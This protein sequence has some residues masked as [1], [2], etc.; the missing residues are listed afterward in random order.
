MFNAIPCF[1]FIQL[2]HKGVTVAHIIWYAIRKWLIV[3]LIRWLIATCEKCII[4]YSYIYY[5]ISG[6][7]SLKLNM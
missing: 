3:T 2:L 6:V 7:Y 4:L 5:C 1:N